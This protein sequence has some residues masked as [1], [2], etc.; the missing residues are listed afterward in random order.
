MTVPK[1]G[2]EARELLLGPSFVRVQ[3]SPD[4]PAVALELR[5]AV[6]RPFEDV[7]TR[8]GLELRTRSIA[9]ISML[10]GLGS[11]EE[12][13]IHFGIA[14]RLGISYSELL[15]IVLHGVYY[16]GSPRAHQAQRAL[17]EAYAASNGSAK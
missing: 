6:G 5:D 7:W 3:P 12:L 17:R 11:T 16:C 9:T 2:D 8:P 1:N 14:L 15:E 4:E 10:I 13:R